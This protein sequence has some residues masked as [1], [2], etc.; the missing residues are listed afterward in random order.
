MTVPTKSPFKAGV[1]SSVTTV[2]DANYTITDTDGFSTIL[3][4]TGAS[5]RTI[6]LP[7]VAANA[8]RR[9]SIKKIDG[10]VGNVTITPN[11]GT[12][13]GI[14]TKTINFIHGVFDLVSD[15]TNWRV[16]SS[17]QLPLSDVTIIS[18]T[19]TGIPVYLV[20]SNGYAGAIKSA[21][22]AGN[23]SSLTVG[24]FYPGSYHVNV[25]I[26]QASNRN[27]YYASF[28]TFNGYEDTQI[29][30]LAA[31]AGAFW[32]G[33]AVTFSLPGSTGNLVITIASGSF[34][35]GVVAIGAFP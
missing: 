10:G 11:G 2:T 34:S 25:A 16:Q 29:S 12:I 6:T 5:T 26:Q 20:T 4:S 32:S 28:S 22:S 14:A 13:D 30:N 3:V 7:A 31:M 23:V 19:P 18:P 9:L 15:G 21:K 35:I 27:S 8:G 17:G 1:F 33:G 24:G